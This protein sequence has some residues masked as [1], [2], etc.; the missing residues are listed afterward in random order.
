M[1]PEEAQYYASARQSRLPTEVEWRRAAYVRDASWVEETAAGT[2]REGKA[3]YEHLL[4]LAHQLFLTTASIGHETRSRIQPPGRGRSKPMNVVMPVTQELTNLVAEIQDLFAE[5][6][7][8]KWQWGEIGPI[9]AFRQDISVFGVRNVLINA[10]ELV[11]SRVHETLYAPKRYPAV[12]D[13]SLTR[14]TWSTRNLEESLVISRGPNG[15]DLSY[16][17]IVKRSFRT[18]ALMKAF[19]GGTGWEMSFDT[20]ERPVMLTASARVQRFIYAGF[21]CAR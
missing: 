19:R 6:S 3:I 12:V 18:I 20:G 2:A 13:P 8:Y 14:Y 16:A 11:Q 1:L 5:L 17:N 7:Q 10:P 15:E 4:R 21:R 9:D